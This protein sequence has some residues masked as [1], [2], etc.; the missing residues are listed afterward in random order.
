MSKHRI[1]ASSTASGRIHLA[2]PPSTQA[3]DVLRKCW[4]SRR[5]S[6]FHQLEFSRWFEPQGLLSW[7]P[8][9]THLNVG[10]ILSECETSD[11]TPSFELIGTALR[12]RLDLLPDSPTKDDIPVAG[13]DFLQV[14]QRVGEAKE[15]IEAADDLL[16]KARLTLE[17]VNAQYAAA[18]PKYD[19]LLELGPTKHHPSCRFHR[20]YGTHR[21]LRISIDKDTSQGIDDPGQARL[22]VLDGILARGFVILGRSF[23]AYFVDEEDSIKTVYFFATNGGDITIPVSLP[24]FFRDHIDMSLDYNLNQ[25]FPKLVSRIKLGHS[26]TIKTVEIALEDVIIVPD[27]WSDTLLISF[28]AM[29]AIAYSLGLKWVP[30]AIRGTIGQGV[31]EQNLTWRVDDDTWDGSATP[32]E[33]TSTSAIWIQL[34]GESSRKDVRVT[35]LYTNMEGKEKKTVAPFQSEFV[36]WRCDDRPSPAK[37]MSDGCGMASHEILKKVALSMGLLVVPAWLQFRFAGCKGVLQAMPPNASKGRR[38][39]VRASQLKFLVPV[40]G[41]K[42]YHLEVGLVPTPPK[43]INIGAQPIAVLSHGGV[44]NSLFE[45]LT[46]TEATEVATAFLSALDSPTPIALQEVFART[47]LASTREGQMAKIFAQEQKKREFKS[48]PWVDARSGRVNGVFDANSGLPRGEAEGVVEAMLAGFDV[49]SEPYLAHQAQKLGEWS[50]APTKGEIKIKVGK[51]CNLVATI[52][53]LGVLQKGEVS[54]RFDDPIVDEETKVLKKIILG[55]V[56]VFRPPTLAPNDVQKV[57]A[58]DKPQLDFLPNQL[59]CSIHGYR[60]LLSLLSGGD[61]DGDIVSIIWEP[62]FVEPFRPSSERFAD[63]PVAVYDYIDVDKRIAKDVLGPIFQLPPGDKQTRQLS[64]VLCSSL[65]RSSK[66]GLVAWHFENIAYKYGLEHENE[67]PYLAAHLFCLLLDGSKHG[68]SIT[69]EKFDEVVEKLDAPRPYYKRIFKV[70]KGSD[71]AWDAEKKLEARNKKFKTDHPLDALVKL[72][73]RLAGQFGCTWSATL[74][75]SD[76]RAS[77]PDQDLIAPFHDAIKEAIKYSD[78]A[79]VHDLIEIYTWTSHMWDTVCKAYNQDKFEDA[80]VASLFWNLADLKASLTSSLGRP[81]KAG[82]LRLLVASATYSY[83]LALPP[84]PFTDEQPVKKAKPY[85]ER[86]TESDKAGLAWKW[87]WKLCFRELLFIKASACTER[88]QAVYVGEEGARGAA[89][90]PVVGDLYL[91]LR[92][93]RRPRALEEFQ[94]GGNKRRKLA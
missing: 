20:Q 3:Y 80:Q 35:F 74:A 14:A 52:D 26:A 90:L 76:R 23:E 32:Q 70:E 84:S 55:E 44:P 28:H 51:S 78:H 8:L 40:T 81:T 50:I 21:F 75:S 4:K 49:G 56:L 68:Y 5:W 27:I 59:V 58:V 69:T 36:E 45:E 38:I 82:L 77:K 42:M 65:W 89:A 39:E 16:V 19:T 13:P 61:Y 62:K 12:R 9:K 11:G 2:G 71:Q 46:R 24:D 72:S 25:K 18:V 17:Q 79:E 94:D 64:G 43:P 29:S 7:E 60:S 92:P 66:F 15:K 1:K 57:V 63:P 22:P 48:E 34:W 87:A 10:A 83:K 93:L 41:Q 47:K 73:K 30:S 86:G 37:E 53:P 33:A 31:S 91:A 67:L 54:I 6:Y 85:I 88:G